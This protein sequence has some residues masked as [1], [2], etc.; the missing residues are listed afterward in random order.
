MLSQSQR[1]RILSHLQ[2]GW[3]LPDS[4]VQELWM[5]YEALE[6]SQPRHDASAH[7]EHEPSSSRPDRRS[8]GG[9]SSSATC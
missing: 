9:N 1:E 7:S 2:R 4:L 3:K 8:V 6:S 5:A